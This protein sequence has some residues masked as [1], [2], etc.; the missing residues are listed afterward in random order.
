MKRLLI[1]GASGDLGRPLSALATRSWETVGTFFRHANIGGGTAVQLDLR[2]RQAV[3]DLVEQVKPTAII[4]A[5]TSD[6]SEDM[7]AANRAAAH[8]ISEA[9]QRAKCRLIA[10]STDLIFDGKHPPYDE[11]APPTPISPYGQVKAENERT[12]LNTPDCL[13]V[14][15]SLIYDLARTNRQVSWMLEKIEARETV[16]LFTDEIRQPIWAWNLAEALLELATNELSGILH[17]AGPQPLSRYEYGS[18]LLHALGYDPIQVVRPVRAA[19]MMPERP[20]DCT[21][22]L[23]KAFACLRTPLLPVDEALRRAKTGKL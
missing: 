11:Q 22:S 12:F 5:G 8:N 10:L 23:E 2:N 15:T 6:R 3:L 21:L 17:V 7:A 16:P 18:R 4:H 20:R 1:T 13:I 14:R 19:D 9:A